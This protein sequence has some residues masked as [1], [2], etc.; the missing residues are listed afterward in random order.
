MPNGSR[1]QDPPSSQRKLITWDWELKEISVLKIPV[2]E[3]SNSATKERKQ[4]SSRLHSIPHPT[5]TWLK[6]GCEVFHASKHP[7]GELP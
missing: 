3:D 7:L 6:T 4:D 2:G 1:V 5:G